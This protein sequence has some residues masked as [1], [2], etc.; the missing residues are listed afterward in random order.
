MIHRHPEH[1]KT[2]DYIGLHRYSLRFCTDTRRPLFTITER[3]DLVLEQFVRAATEEG[4]AIIAY[5]FMPD[6]VHLL[7]EGLQESSDCKR[8]MA[9][10]KQ[11][12]GYYYKKRFSRRLWQRYGYERIL[13]SDDATL[14]V[15]RY[16]VMNPIRAGLATCVES[17][18]F[19]GSLVLTLGQLLEGVSESE[20][21]G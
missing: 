7:I 18:P 13:R 1:L 14:T 5:C 3:V 11:Y 2:F 9:K 19:V 21:S 15:A 8:F 4:F 10:A 16:I 12:A 6:H 17:Y 20:W